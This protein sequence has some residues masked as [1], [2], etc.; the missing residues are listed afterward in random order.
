MRQ[1]NFE[2]AMEKIRACSDFSC[3]EGISADEIAEYQDD[4]C[5]R[6]SPMHKEFMQKYGNISFKGFD[7]FGLAEQIICD[8]NPFNYD[9]LDFN[10]EQEKQARPDGWL[11]IMMYDD[12]H[13]A[14]LDYSSVV[15]G[16][17]N[18]KVA[19]WTGFC[20]IVVDDKRA[21]DLGDYLLGLVD[22]TERSSLF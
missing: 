2:L 3:G 17:P 20:H 10:L 6:L 1:K 12:E 16:E 5:L 21:N 19:Y 7:I 15:G 11:P 14:Y 8:G 4:L 18:I 13:I 9:D 22:D